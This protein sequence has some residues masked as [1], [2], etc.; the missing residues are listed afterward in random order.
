LGWRAHR[1]EPF[2]LVLG[3]PDK[4]LRFLSAIFWPIR[5]VAWLLLPFTFLSILIMIKHNREYTNDWLRVVF[6]VSWWPTLWIGEHIQ[7]L[8]T[9]VV[10]GMVII[11]YGGAVHQFRIRA[12]LGVLLRGFVD[13]TSLKT[14]PLRCQLWAHA[15]TLLVRATTFNAGTWVWIYYRDTHPTVSLIALF[16]SVLGA[17]TFLATACPLLPQEGYHILAAYTGQPDL[18]M[19][20]YR[21]LGLRLRGRP[22]PAAMSK[23]EMWGLVWFALGIGLVSFVYVGYV[24]IGIDASAVQAMGGFGALIVIG[25]YALSAVYFFSLRRFARKM[26]ALQQRL[27][28]PRGRAGGGGPPPSPGGFRFRG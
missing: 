6:N 15:S 3:D 2:T 24:W 1:K 17:F 8:I 25:V 7:N 14:M 23:F 5:R 13:E 4:F 28:S 12:F 9:R 22:V 27:G 18:M 21:V 20:A 19:R 26:R 10:E 11:G 16:C